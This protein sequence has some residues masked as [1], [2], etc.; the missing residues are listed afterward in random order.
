MKGGV[1]RM[2]TLHHL[3]VQDDG[4]ATNGRNTASGG[5]GE[6]EPGNGKGKE[7]GTVGVRRKVPETERAENT[8]V[9]VYQRT[10]SCGH[11]PTGACDSG[12]GY[13]GGRLYRYSTGGTSGKA[14]GRD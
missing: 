6:G 9:R 14:Q 13:N 1:Y 12:Q 10:D 2:L 11:L 7:T 4:T 8:A 5:T 3:V